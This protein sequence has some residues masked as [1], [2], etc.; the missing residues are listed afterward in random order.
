MKNKVT[1]TV[2]AYTNEPD[3]NGRIYSKKAI[4]KAIKG[5][6]AMPIIDRSCNNNVGEPYGIPKIVGI[7]EK[8]K[9]KKWKDVIEFKGR[10]MNAELS[11]VLDPDTGDIEFTDLSLLPFGEK[12]E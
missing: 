4:K 9:F 3:V 6:E 12:G 2:P 7:I 10:L 8:A 1:I 5:L 11:Y